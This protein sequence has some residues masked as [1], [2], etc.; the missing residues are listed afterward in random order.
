MSDGRRLPSLESELARAL[1]SGA[2]ERALR[3]EIATAWRR[4]EYLGLV[5]ELRHTPSD[6][7]TADAALDLPTFVRR[8]A[9]ELEITD[10]RDYQRAW[11]RRD[12]ARKKR[13]T[14]DN[15]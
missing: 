9:P 13:V 8:H 6:Q 4:M 14:L 10:R 2:S 1:A 15:S 11:R 7:E 5:R 3:D 12:A